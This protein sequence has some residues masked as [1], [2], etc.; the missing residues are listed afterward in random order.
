MFTRL[1][2]RRSP[3]SRTRATDW[4]ATGAGAAARLGGVL[5]ATRTGAMGT[6]GA[7]QTLPDATLMGV[8]ATSLGLGAGF[9]LARAP[10]LAV[11]AGIV[12]AIVMGA[13]VLLRPVRGAAR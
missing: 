12:P 3:S 5:R 13:A 1:R 4:P 9:Y 2:R 11:A 7:L 10:R 8:A 6:T